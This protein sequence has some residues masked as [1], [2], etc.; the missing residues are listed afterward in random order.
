MTASHVARTGLLTAA[1]LAIA[2]LVALGGAGV[3][4]ALNHLPGTDARPELTWAGDA[5]AVPALDAATARLQALSDAVDA[6]GGDARDALAELVGGDAA[7]LSG[8]IDAGGKQLAAV[9]IASDA[10]STSLAAI[11]YTGAH[12][13]LFLS[14]AVLHRYDELQKT[15]GV[16]AGL[17]GNWAVLSARALSAASVPALLARHDT[18]TVA[19]AKEGTGGHYQQALALLDAPDAT[20]ATARAIAGRL[21]DVSDV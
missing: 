15:R 7:A 4:A 16:D 18:Q 1:W 14:P 5:V 21:A 9:G 17:A 2:I 20:I 10:L 19:A 8:T 13:V 6:L 11:P 3:V 12:G